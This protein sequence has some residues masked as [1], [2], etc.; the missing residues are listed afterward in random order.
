MIV[1]VDTSAF[2]AIMDGSDANHSNTISQWEALLAADDTLVTT[3]WV[4]VE[5]LALLQHRLGLDAVRAFQEDI[6]PL[7]RIQWPDR[8]LFEAGV[9]AVLTAM[10]RD[11]SVVDCASF[12]VMRTLGA[13]H[14]FAFDRHFE[15]QGFRGMEPDNSA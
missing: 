9:A 10:R 8:A 13:Q 11:L 3:G 12:I 7:L 15:E 1:F 2:Y 14:A 4:L 5:T 6:Y